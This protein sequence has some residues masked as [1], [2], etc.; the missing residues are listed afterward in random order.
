MVVTALTGESVGTQQIAQPCCVQRVLPSY[1]AVHGHSAYARK[2]AVWVK[3]QASPPPL[4]RHIQ[5]PQPAQQQ[6]RARSPSRQSRAVATTAS[7]RQQQGLNEE[8]LARVQEVMDE[9]LGP[10]LSLPV[11]RMATANTAGHRGAVARRHRPTVGRDIPFFGRKVKNCPGGS[12]EAGQ[13]VGLRDW[14]YDAFP[15]N[16]ARV[17]QLRHGGASIPRAPLVERLSKLDRWNNPLAS[18]SMRSALVMRS[19][20]WCL[21]ACM[22]V[23]PCVVIN[24]A[25]RNTSAVTSAVSKYVGGYAAPAK[26]HMGIVQRTPGQDQRDAGQGPS[27]TSHG[28]GSD[29]VGVQ[30]FN[31]AREAMLQPPSRTEWDAH[32][33]TG[34]VDD[35]LVGQL[36]FDDDGDVKPLVG[37][38]STLPARYQ[39]RFRYVTDAAS[40]VGLCC[41]HGVIQ[42]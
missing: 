31:S 17:A 15:E 28:N 29:H 12:P 4:P 21:T 32:R 35:G 11:D 3:G 22:V 33:A 2:P 14:D 30:A 42:S 39:N 37:P 18:A 34:G 16:S 26:R 19:W 41:L 24:D 10:N 6:P 40:Q 8:E 25:D 20:G 5:P 27:H 1:A 38:L 13:R 23:A 36:L 9:Q 7:R